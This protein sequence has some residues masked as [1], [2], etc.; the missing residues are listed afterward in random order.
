MQATC[1]KP[2]GCSR[3]GW[4]IRGCCR[5]QAALGC[6]PRGTA[7]GQL[8]QALD[9]SSGGAIAVWQPVILALRWQ[10][11][12]A[13]RTDAIRQ[14]PFLI[15]S[16]QAALMSDPHAAIEYTGCKTLVSTIV[17][18]TWR[19]NPKRSPSSCRRQPG[20]CRGP[21]FGF[22]CL[23]R[24]GDRTSISMEG[25]DIDWTEPGGVL[26][27][28]AVHLQARR[29]H[30]PRTGILQLTEAVSSGRQILGRCSGW[31]GTGAC[32]YVRPPSAR[33]GDPARAKA[34]EGAR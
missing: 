9:L 5:K 23:R 22:C 14:L 6:L 15:Y 17:H 2:W 33:S 7:H 24:G 1:S 20:M 25:N 32:P 19:Q 29:S 12:A 26:V 28:H 3:V 10:G 8:F 13:V 31:A 21:A 30:L 34:Q 4:D 27:D 16:L 18:P 11:L